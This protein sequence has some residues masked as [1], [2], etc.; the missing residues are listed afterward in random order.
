MTS[1]IFNRLYLRIWFAFLGVLLVFGLLL[2]GLWWLLPDDRAGGD[3]LETVALLVGDA[4]PASPTD[5]IPRPD[6]PPP[7]PG[8]PP[9]PEL[10]Q[11]IH[12][13]AERLSAD[14]TVHD[15]AG[16]LTA[17]SGR[18]LPPPPPDV[19]SSRVLRTPGGPIVILKLEDGRTVSVGI[20]RRPPAVGL[21]GAAGLLL[22]TT[23]VGA[24][25]VVRR[26]TQ[27]LERLRARVEALGAGDLKARIEVEGRDEVADLARSFNRAAERIEALVGGQRSMLANVSH[28]LRS[29]LARMR[30][31]AELLS[32]PDRPELKARLTQDIAELDALID[33]LLESSRLDAGV[34]ADRLEDVDLL[35]LL[36]EEAAAVDAE[37]S[38]QSATLRGEPRLLR[39]M[40][41]NL[42]E[43]ARRHGGPSG[44]EAACSPSAA[45]IVLTVSDRGPGV[46]EDER[47]RIFEPF[48]RLHGM[49]ETGEGVGLGLALVRQIA[50]RHGGDVR[51]FAREGGGSVFAV[52]LQGAPK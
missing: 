14:V 37:V 8:P 44:I 34:A 33:E 38:G 32:S 45:G 43:N 36:A 3:M 47:E 39:R 48:H 9:S 20:R 52:T 5:R 25:F 21:A 12:R 40:I 26:V 22:A 28:E 31:A 15:A 46:P 13:I 18:P 19:R 27:R 6:A 42:L 24:F 7:K 11:R 4:L 41:R 29:P 10:Q 35:A 49:R 51:C 16:R 2:G 1:R 30:M 17:H 50:R 23:A